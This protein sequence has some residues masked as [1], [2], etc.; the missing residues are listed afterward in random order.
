MSGPGFAGGI[1][2]RGLVALIIARASL[3][4]CLGAQNAAAGSRFERVFA[5]ALRKQV[6]SLSLVCGSGLQDVICWYGTDV[7]REDVPSGTRALSA[8][9]A[10]SNGA[11][12]AVRFWLD[13][14]ALGLYLMRAAPKAVGRIS[15]GW[16]AGDIPSA[17]NVQPAAALRL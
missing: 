6:R 2:A 8:P 14:A 11:T 3:I 10:R 12:Q 1:Q 15:K 16:L 4:P 13:L 9:L 7:D 17:L 5:D